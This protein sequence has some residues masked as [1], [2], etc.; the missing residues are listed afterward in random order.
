MLAVLPDVVLSVV[1]VVVVTGVVVEPEVV[2]AGVVVDPIDSMVINRVS[3]CVQLTFLTCKKSHLH[4]NVFLTNNNSRHAHAILPHANFVSMKLTG[5]RAHGASRCRAFC[6]ATCRCH[7]CGRTA[8]RC[9]D[10]CRSGSYQKQ[11]ASKFSY[12]LLEISLCLAR[13]PMHSIQFPHNSHTMFEFNVARID[14][15]H[16]YR[17]THRHTHTHTHRQTDRD[18]QL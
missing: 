13:S 14:H 1:P 9:C 15:C 4:R 7:R 2:D 12:F 6:C 17:Q 18:L 16:H 3:V 11:I 8:G 5:R 10:W